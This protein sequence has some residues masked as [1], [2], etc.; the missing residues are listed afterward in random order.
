MYMYVHVRVYTCRYTLYM[1]MY[2]CLLEIKMQ[3][4]TSLNLVSRGTYNVLWWRDHIYERE[5]MQLNIYTVIIEALY[6]IHE[7]VFLLL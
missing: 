6:E 2:V 3:D 4:Y 1:Y 7:Q 5:P